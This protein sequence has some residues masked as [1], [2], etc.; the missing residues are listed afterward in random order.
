MASN[1]LMGIACVWLA[2]AST[3]TYALFIAGRIF[4]G[5]FEAPIEA[6]TPSTITDV[7]F[8]HDRG[9]YVS[10][11]GLSVLSGNAIGPVVSAFVIQW[12]GMRWA[13]LVVAMII[14]F[15]VVL[16]FFGMPE[17]KYIGT[18]ASTMAPEQTLY[19]KGETTE[20]RQEIGAE[21]NAATNS[22]PCQSY[23]STLK[24]WGKSDPSVSLGRAFLRPFLVVVGGVRPF[25]VLERHTWCDSSPTLRPTVSH[26]F[27][28]FHYLIA[29]SSGHRPYRFDSSAQGLVFISLFIG[30]LIGTYLSGPI[31]DAVAN[32]FT[33]RNDG[34]REPEMRLPTCAIAAAITAIGVVIAAVTYNA[35]T[36]W[37]GPVVGFGILSAGAQMGATL[38]ITYS[39]DC[40]RELSA[41]LMVT[42]S[43]IKSLVAWVWT[44]IIND[45]INKNGMLTVFLVV[46]AINLVV[47][48]ST[49]IL[50]FQGKVL[51]SWIHR[52]YTTHN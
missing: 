10:A 16:M 50:F 11:Y 24:L 7:F 27:T 44:W 34:I 22:V 15:S 51:R 46:M 20:Y 47:Y 39:L 38:A 28:N 52:T 49:V 13:F 1:I 37:A 26:S 14:A 33:R 45:W 9:L 36:H 43:A 3:R 42:I 17:T 40:H 6:I 29:G 8:L 35:K 48:A 31:A 41:E 19:A 4:L 2:L 32:Y 30:S 21:S 12:R 5:I 18:R 23:A 25:V